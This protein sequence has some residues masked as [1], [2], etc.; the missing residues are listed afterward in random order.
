MAQPLIFQNTGTQKQGTNSAPRNNQPTPL[1]FSKPQQQATSPAFQAA[2]RNQQ[3]NL[4]TPQASASGVPRQNAVNQQIPV[5]TNPQPSVL[6]QQPQKSFWDSAK[7]LAGQGVNM[8]KEAVM[9]VPKYTKSAIENPSE[10]LAGGGSAV[11][12]NFASIAGLVQDG[13]T[14]ALGRQKMERFDISKQLTALKELNKDVIKKSGDENGDKQ[15][16]FEVGT[17]IGTALPY[18][19]GGQVTTLASA[20]T[21]LPLT[22]RFMPKAVKFVPAINEAVSAIGVGQILHDRDAGGTR[23][24]QLK[25]DLTFF[26]LF[27][28]AGFSLGQSSKLLP[29]K[30]QTA[31]NNVVDKYSTKF[32]NGED[33]QV[34]FLEKDI[35]KVKELVKKDTGK[36]VEAIIGG[37]IGSFEGKKLPFEVKKTKGSVLKEY[38]LTTKNNK[39]V[40]TPITRQQ[41]EKAQEQ[42]YGLLNKAETPEQMEKAVNAL[43]SAHS[44]DKDRLK[45]IRAAFDKEMKSMSGASGNYY[46][47]DYKF[48]QIAKQDSQIGPYLN[49]VQKG[50]DEI[51]NILK[52]DV[53]SING[54]QKSTTKSTQSQVIKEGQSQPPKTTNAKVQPLQDTENLKTSKLGL[55]VEKTAIEKKLTTDLGDLP[56]YKTMNMK[57]QASKAS[58]LIQSDPERALRVALGQEAPP[59]GLVPESVF[60][61]LESSVTTPEMARRLANSPL[62]TEASTLGQR[63]KA[64]DVRTSESSIEAMSQVIKARENTIKGKGGAEKLIKKTVDEV[65]SKV[66]TPDKYDWNAF[67]SSISC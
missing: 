36:S 48:V 66:K 18:A 17:V 4:N 21:L 9:N 35:N 40:I 55:R 8:A 20:K 39:E 30:T 52:S 7:D 6:P 31:I 44:S 1:I 15:R 38:E 12:T 33:V 43:V 67:I 50:I 49:K 46:K 61:A 28:V 3:I 25:T 14:N 42:I 59:S 13:V 41:R 60:K 16:A 62:V 56:Q 53:Q 22:T 34:G 57:E 5:A 65:K 27:K 37:D 10:T 47:D 29:K 19:L 64:L 23:I 54:A 26:G 58:S 11:L 51:D 2:Q 45:V 32:K 24:D 63:I